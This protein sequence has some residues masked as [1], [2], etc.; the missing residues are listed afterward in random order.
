MWH[1]TAILT[2]LS[3]LVVLFLSRTSQIHHLTTFNSNP[4]ILDKNNYH[5]PVT[6]KISTITANN[7]WDPILCPLP[8]AITNFWTHKSIKLIQWISSGRII[9]RI[10]VKV[11]D[12]IIILGEYLCNNS[13]YRNNSLL[14]VWIMD[15]A[16]LSVRA[17]R[18]CQW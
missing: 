6:A 3:T 10:W 11:R 5:F 13:N 12:P 2:G 7:I 15:K 8:H 18:S 9:N 4:I 14:L 1:K 17:I 16:L